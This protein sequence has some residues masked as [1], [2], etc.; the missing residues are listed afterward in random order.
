MTNNL[1]G[2]AAYTLG[3][4]SKEMLLAMFP[5]KNPKTIAH[6]ITTAFGVTAKDTP[7][8]TTA[9][10]VGYASDTDIEALVV[11]VGNTTTRSNGGVYHI[12]W[13]LD[14]QTRKPVDSNKMLASGWNNV[15]PVSIVIHP[16]FFPF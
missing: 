12:T 1:K 15:D 13:S 16:A 11:E 7:K 2:Y 9:R 5:P 8:A 3:H 10:V 14:P 4:A 6:H